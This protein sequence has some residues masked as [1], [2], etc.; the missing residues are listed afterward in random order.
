[1]RHSTNLAL[2]TVPASAPP[3]RGTEMSAIL[4]RLA[5]QRLFWGQAPAAVEQKGEAA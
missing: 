3:R 1:M 2:Q 5:V 4:C